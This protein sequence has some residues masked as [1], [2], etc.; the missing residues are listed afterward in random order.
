MQVSVHAQGH[1]PFLCGAHFLICTSTGLSQ[2]K[3]KDC[4]GATKKD[5]R[6]REKDSKAKTEIH[7]DQQRHPRRP[8][9]ILLKDSLRSG[10][11]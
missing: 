2:R 1:L 10:K 7:R 9:E 8:G 4:D 11:L 3:S 5:H 6:V